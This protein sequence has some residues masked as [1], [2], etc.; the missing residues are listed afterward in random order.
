MNA[1][2][3]TGVSTLHRYIPE[4]LEAPRFVAN[5]GDRIR[6]RGV[7]ISAEQVEAVALAHPDVLECAAIGVPSPL[8]EDDIKLCLR[9]V[10]AAAADHVALAETLLQVLPRALTVRYYE[11][12][13]DLPK[14]PTRKVEKY[15]IRQEGITPDTWDRERAGLGLKRERL[16]G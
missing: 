2:V 11:L 7:N 13:D 8:G 12:F 10:P 5:A 6:R 9:L 16:I 1:P 15:L 4:R 14:T 3:K